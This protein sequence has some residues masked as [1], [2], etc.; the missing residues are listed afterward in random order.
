MI[1]AGE[2]ESEAALARELRIFRVRVNHFIRLLKLDAELIEAI[3]QLGDPLH[4]QIVTERMLRPYVN[5]PVSEQWY[6]LQSI[7]KK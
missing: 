1:D 4:S 7:I 5:K 3:E 2:V 6:F